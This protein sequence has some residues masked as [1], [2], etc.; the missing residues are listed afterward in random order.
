MKLRR[1]RSRCGPLARHAISLTGWSIL[2]PDDRSAL[3]LAD[4]EQAL[5]RRRAARTLKVL[6]IP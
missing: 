4:A 2:R 1:D 5:A 3:S 6:L